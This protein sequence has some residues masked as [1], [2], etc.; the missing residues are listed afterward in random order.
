MNNKNYNIIG[1]KEN[2]LTTNLTKR[3]LNEAREKQLRGDVNTYANESSRAHERHYLNARK[4]HDPNG[5]RPHGFAFITTP[6]FQDFA[7]AN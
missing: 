4:R 1:M 7:F 5:V 3:R 6:L 2:I